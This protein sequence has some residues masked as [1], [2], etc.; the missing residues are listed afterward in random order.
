MKNLGIILLAIMTTAF[1][2]FAE[3]LC[4]FKDI[5]FGSKKRD[6]LSKL[7]YKHNGSLQSS[8]SY[9][10]SPYILG[11]RHVT[12]VAEFDDNDLFYQFVFNFKSYSPDEDGI[13]LIKNDYSYIS[14]IFANKYGISAK[15]NPI[16]KLKII[17][18]DKPEPLQE[19]KGEAC[20]A[21][22]GI[23]KD[24]QKFNATAAVFD[25][26]LRNAQMARRENKKLD[27]FNRAKK[28][29]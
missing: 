5:P 1:P 9:S 4:Q 23:G 19:W 20:Q 24:F 2:L 18:I 29:F 16:D 6:V 22:V 7:D 21:Y 26:E 3:E 10:L 17:V 28:D 25:T 14:T 11:D 12:L 15:V 8:N 13:E 27:G